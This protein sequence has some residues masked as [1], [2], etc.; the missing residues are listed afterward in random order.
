MDLAYDAQ[1]TDDRQVQVGERAACAHQRGRAV[2]DLAADHV[3]DHVDRSGIREV[4][5]LQ[6]Q[7]GIRAETEYGVP[8][9]GPASADHST[10]HLARE[11]DRDQPHTARGAMDQDGLACP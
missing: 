3:E 2:E 1:A 5:G 11:L 8:V 4:V 10:S 7:E 9:S 6:V